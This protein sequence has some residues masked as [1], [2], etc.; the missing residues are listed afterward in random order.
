MIST[1]ALAGSAFYDFGRT[2]DRPP[3]GDIADRGDGQDRWHQGLDLGGRVTLNATFIVALD[4]ALPVD[5]AMD[6]LG[7]K[8]Y[9][10]LDWLF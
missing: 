4:V 2:F 8:V 6:G 10:G 9:I 1:T 7:L 5:M 3:P